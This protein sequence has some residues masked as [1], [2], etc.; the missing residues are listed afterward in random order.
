M[1]NSL[2]V[3]IIDKLLDGHYS[4][5]PVSEKFP[6]LLGKSFNDQDILDLI[7]FSLQR[8]KV[9]YCCACKSTEKKYG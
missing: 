6:Q 4:E 1:K 9:D 7:V 2:K 8:R 3:E 5:L